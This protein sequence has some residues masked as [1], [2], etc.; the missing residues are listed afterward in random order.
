MTG[1]LIKRGYQLLLQNL[2]T[3][4]YYAYCL[5]PFLEQKIKSDK[6]KYKIWNQIFLENYITVLLGE[7]LDYYTKL[8]QWIHDF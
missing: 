6:L 5:S 7:N 4:V 2:D 8:E 1:A 3:K